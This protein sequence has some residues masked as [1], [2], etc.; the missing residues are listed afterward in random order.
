MTS[1]R[2]AENPQEKNDSFQTDP[3]DNKNIEQQSHLDKEIIDNQEKNH[4]NLSLKSSDLDSKKSSQLLLESIPTCHAKRSLLVSTLTNRAKLGVFKD[5]KLE[6]Y[7][8]EPLADSTPSQGDIYY[9]K[10]AKISSGIEAAFVDIDH[11][12][13]AFLHQS[14][15]KLNEDD[16]DKPLNKLLHIGQ[17]ILVQVLK[18]PMGT[19]GARVTTKISLA[20][21]YLVYLPRTQE[22]KLSSKITC[23]DMRET[24]LNKLEKLSVKGLIARTAACSLNLESLEHDAVFLEQLWRKIEQKTLSLTGPGLIQKEMNPPLKIIRDFIKLGLEQIIV[25]CPILKKEVEQ[26]YRDFLPD[27][28]IDISYQ[29][30][31]LSCKSFYEQK[32]KLNSP[33]VYLKSGGN[34]VIEHTESMTTIDVNTASFLGK[35]NHHDTIL[36]T[37]LEAAQAITWE[38]RR[39]QIGGII[40]IDFIDMSCPEDQHLVEQALVEASFDDIMPISI[41]PFTELGLIQISRKRSGEPITYQQTEICGVCHASGRHF[42]KEFIFENIIEELIAM[43]SL[44]GGKKIQVLATKNL[45]QY[46]S[47]QKETLLELDKRFG[48]TLSTA[49][50]E[51]FLDLHYEIISLN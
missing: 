30:D 39:R 51:Y 20:T 44:Y 43:K 24:T 31:V 14:D 23:P 42:N 8:Q 17:R 29:K 10:V 2:F 13:S 22:N 33:L 35:D 48:I 5:D 15:M 4:G 37:N 46:I 21:S 28:S 38:L 1:D 11:K 50:E 16:R 7:Y 3:Q 49:I 27:K 32:K 47:S 41:Y 18:A 34:I 19:K 26:F 25:D 36:K 40:I 6:Y 45:S 9:A 12:R